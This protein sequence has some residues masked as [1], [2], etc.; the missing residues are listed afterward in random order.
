MTIDKYL[1]SKTTSLI[2][3]KFDNDTTI[4]FTLIQNKK[5]TS[6]GTMFLKQSRYDIT[7]NK[8]PERLYK[9]T[10]VIGTI[11]YEQNADKPLQ[12]LTELLVIQLINQL[13]F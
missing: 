3:V 12:N 2:A 10:F 1:S 6:Q 4:T 5:T 11:N 8:L 13:K 7:W 9:N